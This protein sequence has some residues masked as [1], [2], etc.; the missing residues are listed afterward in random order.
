M[1]PAASSAYPPQ[2]IDRILSWLHEL[3]V[4]RAGRVVAIPGGAVLLHDD[5]PDAYDHNKLSVTADHDVADAFESIVS[6]AG[7]DYRSIELRTTAWSRLEPTLIARGYL[8]QDNLLMVR[9]ASS[10]RPRPPGQVVE[11]TLDQRATAAEEGWRT[12][13]PT[14][15]P[16]VCRQLGQR[17]ST[18]CSAADATFLAILDEAGTPVARAD[19]YVYDSL[20]QIEEVVTDESYRGRGFATLL[21][22]EAIKRAGAAPTFLIAD[23]DDWPKDLYARLGF[24]GTQTLPTYSR[25]ACTKER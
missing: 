19:L 13:A 17:I 14:F 11:L 6:Q 1:S 8:R 16:D 2:V 4:R 3:D 5:F 12:S 23:A 20:A 24:G 9:A 15:T 22:D 21:V 25:Q 18:V 7:R 10:R